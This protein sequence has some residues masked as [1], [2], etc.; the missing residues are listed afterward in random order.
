MIYSDGLDFN[1]RFTS[2][3][4]NLEVGKRHE[5]WALLRHLETFSLQAWLCCGDFNE[6]LY[7]S[8]KQ[9]GTSRSGT[10]MAAFKILWSIVILMI[11]GFLVLVTLGPINIMIAHLQ[12]NVWTERVLI[13]N[14]PQNF[15]SSRWEF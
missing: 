2:F 13:L 11:W 4:G 8:E 5:S 14:L 7:E 9:R 12:R 15:L 10:Q 6:I 1:W 3:Y